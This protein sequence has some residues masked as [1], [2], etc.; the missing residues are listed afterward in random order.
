MPF[1]SEAQ[2]RLMW[3]KHPVIARRWAAEG[4]GGV[5]KKS[6]R[7]LGLRARV[8]AKPRK[9]KGGA[10]GRTKQLE[11][12]L[13]GAG[14]MVGAARGAAGGRPKNP[15]GTY[16][17]ENEGQ[18]I[19]PYQTKRAANRRTAAETQSWRAAGGRGKRPEETF[20]PRGSGS[21][22][23]FPN[24]KPVPRLSPDPA[25]SAEDDRW[26]YRSRQPM[27]SNNQMQNRLRNDRRYHRGDDTRRGA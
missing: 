1:R 22:A 11:D 14:A 13:I 17:V 18:A 2:R 24:G 20:K 19:G 26:D 6:G 15:R 8:A 4:N 7:P 23:R 27:S 21:R 5:V 25:K 10:M 3:A 9:A 12:K 16:Y